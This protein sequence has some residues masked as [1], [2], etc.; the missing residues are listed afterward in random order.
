MKEIIETA[1]FSTNV[2]IQINGN[3]P[4]LELAK[5]P[6]MQVF[7]NL[8]TNAVKH[9]D[10][11]EIKINIA[12]VEQAEDWLFYIQDNGPGI[13]EQ[14]HEKV[15]QIFQTLKTKDETNSTGIGLSVV[16][17]IIDGLGGKIWIESKLGK[18]CTF[19]FT[20]KK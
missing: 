16:R 10:K 5:Y 17:K 6:M 18:G 3:L 14:F 15:F 2:H 20:V 7:S 19:F 11:A 12:G 13:E 9:N 1:S 8:I 4:T